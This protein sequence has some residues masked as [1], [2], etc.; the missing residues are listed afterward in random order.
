MGDFDTL[1]VHDDSTCAL[2]GFRLS[3]SCNSRAHELVFFH[4]EEGNVLP[5]IFFC[6][7]VFL[8]KRHRTSSSFQVVFF[9]LPAVPYNEHSM[10]QGAHW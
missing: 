4:F 7:L 3:S 1:L 6:R 5:S 2:Y 9:I 10:R 8:C